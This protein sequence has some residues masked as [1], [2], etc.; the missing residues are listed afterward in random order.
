MEELIAFNFNSDSQVSRLK[1]QIQWWISTMQQCC[2]SWADGS[3]CQLSQKEESSSHPIYIPFNKN[4]QRVACKALLDR[5]YTNTGLI[6]RELVKVLNLPASIS[7][8]RTSITP[9]GTL[10]TNKVIRHSCA[11]LLCLSMNCMFT[12]WSFLKN[13]AVKWILG[14]LSERYK[15]LISRQACKFC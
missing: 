6:S 3:H 14:K 5:C 10:M 7:S 2:A 11:M 12:L 15:I 1:Q 9:A 8:P 13:V 4:Q